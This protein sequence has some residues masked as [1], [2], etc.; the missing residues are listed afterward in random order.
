[1][2]GGQLLVWLEVVPDDGHVE[3][4]G[5]VCRRHADAMVVPRGWT[6][7][8]RR[9]LRPRLFRVSDNPPSIRNKVKRSHRRR[10]AG[11]DTPEQLS[12]SLA[13]EDAL[14][15]ETGGDGSMLCDSILDDP[16]LDDLALDD[17][18]TVGEIRP[19][20]ISDADETR[21]IPW[22]FEFNECDDLGGVLN[23]D[24]PLLSRAFRG[25]QRSG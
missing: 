23:A 7:D 5:V 19:L 17:E 6:L 4:M 25:Q 2:D 24:S 10:H 20:A 8:D 9:E 1:M 14:G 15:A 22:R 18:V 13:G 21:A 11:E 3:R 16:V 12:L